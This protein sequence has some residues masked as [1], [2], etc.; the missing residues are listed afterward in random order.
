MGGV[1]ATDKG[2]VSGSID[3]AGK[4]LASKD[5][6]YHGTVTEDQDLLQAAT[7]QEAPH[8]T[9]RRP[10]FRRQRNSKLDGRKSLPA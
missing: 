7:S 2:L 4:A 9:N 1:G 10:C 6:S 8:D 5:V 3:L